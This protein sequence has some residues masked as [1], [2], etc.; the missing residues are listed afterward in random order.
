[1]NKKTEG[2]IIR[3]AVVAGVVLLHFAAAYVV[4]GV[5]HSLYSGTHTEEYA[6]IPPEPAAAP[7][8]SRRP[9]SVAKS[10]TTRPTGTESKAREEGREMAS[11]GEY[12]FHA[13]GEEN[14]SFV[15]NFFRYLETGNWP[16]P[17]E[18]TASQADAK[19]N[20]IYGIGGVRAGSLS[21]SSGGGASGGSAGT[22]NNP[23]INV[24]PPFFVS[25]PTGGIND[26]TG[27]GYKVTA[28]GGATL[29]SIHGVTSSG[30]RVWFNQGGQVSAQ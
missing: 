28:T 8:A 15:D 5:I 6:E 17:G 29:S 20:E 27:A 14:G 7:G 2:K 18:K 30:Y 22:A 10:R 13:G 16:K 9:A 26:V 23:T 12:T 4:G 11:G 25:N 21:A 19:K 24:M 3:A 1:M